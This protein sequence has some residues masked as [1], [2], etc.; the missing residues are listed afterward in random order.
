[1]RAFCALP[2]VALLCGA[3]TVVA[4]D[5][6]DRTLPL[7][8]VGLGGDGVA[9]P[10]TGFRP[11]GR[12]E[13]ATAQPTALVTAIAGELQVT[14][15]VPLPSGR[16]PRAEARGH[17]GEVWRDDSV[18]L[19]L[20]P[21]HSH[22]EYFQFVGNAAGSRSDA[23]RRDSG[24]DVPWEFSA[25]TVAGGWQAAF[26]VP[27]SSLGTT[28]AAGTVWGLN[29]CVNLSDAGNLSW[30]PLQASF[31]EPVRFG[32]LRFSNTCNAGV[33]GV[34]G[35]L[36]GGGAI[37]VTARGVAG[38]TIE[39]SRDGMAEPAR[40]M[41]PEA[42]GTCAIP[43]ELPREGRFIAPGRYAWNVTARDAAGG[44]ALR[45]AAERQVRP[46]LT[47]RVRAFVTE[48]ILRAEAEVEPAGLD[49]ARTKVRFELGGTRREVPWQ[50]GGLLT[51]DYGKA[52]VPDGTVTVQAELLEADQV[53]YAQQKSVDRPL[54]PPWL[55]DLTGVSDAVPA[56][57]TPLTV[58]RR[59]D[60]APVVGCW[61][62]DYEFG[63]GPLPEVVVTR[64]AAVLAGPVR[65]VATRGGQPVE[66]DR[67]PAQPDEQAPAA[68][69]LDGRSVSSALTVAGRTRVEFDGMIR[70]DLDLEPT[71]APPEGLLLEIPV[72]PEHA[73][74]LYD[75][76]GRW[77]TMQNSR[78]L[79]AEG[80]AS[81]F[82]PFVW[83]GDEDRGFAWFCESDE[84]WLPADPQRAVTVAREGD[85]VVLRLHLWEGKPLDRPVRYTFG[86]QATPVKQP[87]R[88]P[89]DYRIHHGG[90]YDLHTA[91]A[92]S[93]GGTIVY[94]AAGAIRGDRGTFECWL[95][96]DFDSDPTLP[97]EE[98]RKQG[99]RM[100][101]TL[102]LPNSTN[103]GI[104]WN[105]L[106]QGPVVWVREQGEVTFY[107]GASFAA[108]RGEWHHL[109][110][111][112][113][114]AIHAYIDGAE[115][116]ARPRTGLTA[117]PV[118]PGTITLGGQ[119]CPFALDEV[120]ILDEPRAP[121]APFGPY[122]PDG[123]TLLLDPFDPPPAAQQTAPSVG[124]A[125]RTTGVAPVEGR[126][127]Q[128]LLCGRGDE[129]MTRLER[130]AAAGVRTI[131]FHE[132]WTPWQS[133]PYTSSENEPKLSALVEAIH[134]KDMQLLLYMS[135]QIAD[136]A[137]EY[138]LYGED[139]LSM[140]KQFGYRRQPEQQDWG[141]CWRSHWK[142][143]CLA[144]LAQTMDRF[145]NDGWYLDGPEWPC[146][147]VNRH[148]GCGYVRPDG[149][150]APTYDIFATRDFMRRLYVLT[151]ERRPNG[152]LNI[153]NSTVM[154][155]PTLAWGTST[156]NGEQISGIE[157]GPQ[158]LSVLPLD[159]FRCELTGRQW[160]VPSEFLCYE[161]PWN[162]HEALAITLIHDV[163]VRPNGYGWQLD[164]LSALWRLADEF[165]RSEATF[166][167]Y[168]A[169]SDL[170]ETSD[171][172][173]KVSGYRHDRHGL[174]LVVANLSE[175]AR[176]AGVR[177]DLKALG[178]AAGSTAVNALTREPVPFAE[179]RFEVPL[180]PF[181]YAVVWL[182]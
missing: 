34:A 84:H 10:L 11:L 124:P 111:T 160:G 58:R 36:R 164:E 8:T 178:I 102:G 17:D 49:L 139:V 105:E 78:A 28:P 73:L 168:W 93:G 55:G 118:E 16:Q 181:D 101:F 131:C 163:L 175:E 100:I 86:F 99:N 128:A 132:H 70:C 23:C 51:A 15:T 52:E 114:D 161:R 156:W 5:L 71:G 170:V 50:A 144:H 153:H 54:D 134:A 80:W 91:R 67:I 69:S 43:I 141:V 31:H 38:V 30:S 176:N 162:T 87:E 27:F 138:E 47:L 159:A 140:P 59:G 136:I 88:D 103:M 77:G 33:A 79:P 45:F 182:R 57:W 90:N 63:A 108:K 97:E 85:R 179:G 172:A 3:A 165:G 6:N 76:P 107:A 25:E 143:F 37:T 48:G 116:F 150:I 20:D 104:Y 112:W 32:H 82:K 21:R 133:H 115:V 127:G 157:R 46:P 60:G 152:Q 123:H 177:L 95:R 12:R 65:L 26:R 2:T 166:L 18:E 180:K 94:P 146:P 56:P 42:D 75:F 35:L 29:L 173:V 7:L 22:D 81:P 4:G 66:F 19:F 74:Y 98:R 147:C 13:L 167:P 92:E 106:H 151:R 154:V 142:E 169:N 41:E 40:T 119:N 122:Q 137:P 83:L 130:L 72:K 135:R 174:L 155:I 9:V 149:T 68:V 24:W 171:P 113:G 53:V 64:G 126:F 110:F 61:G 14:V 125:G 109:A 89:W 121:V 158:F 96:F 148:H 117:L 120:R 145:G 62:R 44:P 39:S 1:M 129:P